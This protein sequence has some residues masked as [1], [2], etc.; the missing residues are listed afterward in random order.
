[1][2]FRGNNPDY[3]NPTMNPTRLLQPMFRAR[4]TQSMRA[5]ID[6]PSTQQALLARMIS[7]ARPTE[8]GRNHSYSRISSYSDFAEAVPVTPYEKIRPLVMRMIRG[9]KDVLWPGIT[10]RFA[11]SSG[12]SGGK[13]KYVPV[14]PDMLADGHYRGS[15]LVVAHYLKNHPDSRIFSGRAL[16]LGG[17][18][19]NELGLSDRRLRVGDLSA[20]LIE[21]INPLANMVRTPS[22]RTALMADWH[23]KLPR[24]AAE[25]SRC[26]VS[27]LSG[28]PSWM[29]T[30]LREVMK[31]KGVDE[32]H[33]LWPGL[34]VF[35]HGGIAFGPYR[36]QYDAIIDPARMHYMETY[37]ASEG[38]FA[39]Q[40]DPA[41]A[42]MMLLMD[43]GVFYEFRPVD[44]PDARPLTVADIR[45]GQIYEL[46][47]TTEGGLWRYPL[48]DTVMVHSLSPVKITIAGRTKS[49]INAFGEE[50]MV[51][52]TDAALARTCAETGA[53]VADYT[54][55]PVFAD[56]GRKGHHQWL[57][58][59]DHAPASVDDFARRLDLNLTR[60]NSDYQAKRSGGIF[61][62]PLSVTA[63][64][65]GF[66]DR[67]LESTGKLGGQRKVPRL[68][69]DRTVIESMLRLLKE[70]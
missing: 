61:L 1:M 30:V 64:P 49:F 59:F 70:K 45:P 46:I 28:V 69:N 19:A 21:A 11:Q 52:N 7:T 55:A 36:H 27:N 9:E 56:G 20:N 41:S 65:R 67:W 24:L 5:A 48:G 47:I 26:R 12:T 33:Q 23:E 32:L 57:I 14:T 16:I 40:D 43:C 31:I 4:A 10:R 3:D 68:N 53:V 18:F 2:H 58:E 34:E 6:A 17:S 37:N 22:K 35:F 38:F 50:V 60:E 54:A 42:A 29:L 63:V 13:S 39:L 15:S 62:D 66:F 25:V 44:T 51:F 8:W